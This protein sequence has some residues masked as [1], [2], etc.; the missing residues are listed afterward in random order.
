MG[1]EMDVVIGTGMDVQYGLFY[2]SKGSFT[3]REL[4]K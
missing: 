2:V 4:V 3:T 1:T